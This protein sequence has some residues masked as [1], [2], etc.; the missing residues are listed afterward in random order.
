[1][2]HYPKFTRRIARVSFVLTLLLVPAGLSAQFGDWYNLDYAQDSVMGVSANKAL[3][4][5][6]GRATLTPVLVAVID[7]GV[8]IYHPDFEGRIWINKGETPD[9]GVDNDGNRFVDDVHGWNFLGNPDGENIEFE[10][11][12]LTRLLREMAPSFEGKELGDFKGK[13]KKEFKR[14]E[15]LMAVYNEDVQEAKEE[16]AQFSQLAALYSGA[17]AYAREKIDREDLSVQDLLNYTPDDEEERQVIDFLL[18]AE[19]QGLRGYLDQGSA[20]FDKLLNYYYNFDFDPRPLVN[21]GDE[22]PYGNPMVWAA[23]PDHGTHVAGIIAAVRGNDLGV[24]GIA[25]N[26]V[27]LPIR[28]VPG[29]DERDQDIAAAIRYAVDQGARIINM[30]FGKPYSPDEPLVR[31]A[32]M[33]ARSHDVLMIHAAGNDGSDNDQV[34]NYP[35]GTLGKRKPL[36]N[37]ITVAASGPFA[38]EEL[39]AEFSNYGKRKVD[40]LA[41]GVAIESLAPGGGVATNSGTSMAAPVVA[42]VAA[43]VRGLNPELSAKEVKKILIRTA[44]MMPDNPVVSEESSSPLKKVVRTPGVVSAYEAVKFTEAEMARKSR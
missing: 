43:L 2:H 32:I 26:A 3:D 37:W 42:G 39:L 38:G 10:T 11:L 18:M 12:E 20:H 28:A 31:E 14:Y 17:M 16:F 29:G 13:E 40:V 25:P 34:A 22:V 44:Q 9:D 7:D 19:Q 15:S 5:L 24:D 35:D 41:P 8:D 6:E 27:I 4:Y 30:S 21:E 36:D 33:Y 23:N 1:M